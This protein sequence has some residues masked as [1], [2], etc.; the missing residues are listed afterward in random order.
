MKA[1][2]A[3]TQLFNVTIEQT[4]EKLKTK[5][6]TIKKDFLS[7]LDKYSETFIKMYES[8]T[9]HLNS[10]ISSTI[11]ITN[12]ST[13]FVEKQNFLV[14]FDIKMYAKVCFRRKSTVRFAKR[15]A[16]SLI[17]SLKR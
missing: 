1:V 13:D 2:Q 7:Q 17:Y 10:A 6:Q 9:T 15:T 8:I 16:L 5:D 14:N 12:D 3:N 4:L 11:K